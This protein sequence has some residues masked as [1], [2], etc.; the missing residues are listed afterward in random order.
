MSNK[1]QTLVEIAQLLNSNEYTE[2]LR[3]LRKMHG[4]V[5]RFV[6][7]SCGAMSD[8]ITGQGLISC[9]CGTA[10]VEKVVLESDTGLYHCTTTDA[11][12]RVNECPK[13]VLLI[14]RNTGNVCPF[15][16]WGKE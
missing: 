15:Y 2:A 11:A 8:T 6:C 9:R 12:H 5:N 10:C 14:C 1:L 16:D 3:E 7:S 13:R 4:L